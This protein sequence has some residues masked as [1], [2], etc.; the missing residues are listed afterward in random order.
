M[1][2]LEEKSEN[3]SSHLLNKLSE[4]QEQSERAVN[5]INEELAREQASS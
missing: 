4:E 1:P 2:I 3:S 5:V